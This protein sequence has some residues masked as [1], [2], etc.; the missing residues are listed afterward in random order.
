MFTKQLRLA[1][2]LIFLSFKAGANYIGTDSTFILVKVLNNTSKNN[3][4]INY[5]EYGSYFN[6][7]SYSSSN[8]SRKQVSG[9]IYKLRA[10]VPV[11][12]SVFTN[13]KG[14]IE[15][16]CLPGDTTYLEIDYSNPENP[17]KISGKTADICDFYNAENKAVKMSYLKSYNHNTSTSYIDYFLYLEETYQS[18]DSFYNAYIKE[19]KLPEWFH[20]FHKTNLVYQK[21]LSMVENIHT[22]NYNTRMKVYPTPE[23]LLWFRETPI[24]NTLAIDNQVYFDFLY[25]YFLWKSNIT[26]NRNTGG[27]V[28][29]DW[30]FRVL[31]FVNKELKN[32]VKEWFL[33]EMLVNYYAVK[34]VDEV[35]S[36][37]LSVKPI[38]KNNQY[39]EEINRSRN[40][41]IENK[42]LR[43]AGS[44]KVGSKAPRFHLTDS[45][46]VSYSTDKFLGK[47]ALM[48]FFNSKSFPADS[49]NTKLNVELAETQLLN[50]YTHLN[51]VSWKKTMS[52]YSDSGLHL[53]CKGN[54]GEM[55]TYQYGLRSFPYW[56]LVD[57]KG[58]IQYSGNSDINAVI[59]IL[60]N[61]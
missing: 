33:K 55:V 34:D 11:K 21:A 50:I 61:K 18:H 58:T 38:I 37:F 6:R 4:F 57:P 15:G 1:Y 9:P 44:A 32:P 45:M 30:F 49:F 59:A 7:Y 10:N 42:E 28:Y 41:S 2:L 24:D 46:N 22:I 54:W 16:I 51:P 60:K 53:F 17:A 43:F 36:A 40:K 20:T 12:F 52:K 8:S 19:K 5:S 3:Y 35:D 13:V 25:Q 14:I 48:R 56:V 23:F 26:W 31:P 29:T 47:W 27:K 39:L